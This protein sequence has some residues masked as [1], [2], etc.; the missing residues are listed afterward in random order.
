M[1]GQTFRISFLLFM[2][3][4]VCR[5]LFLMTNGAENISFLGAVFISYFF[6]F[7]FVKFYNDIFKIQFFIY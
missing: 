6:N 2:F 4:K 1:K 3:R 5:L 7:I